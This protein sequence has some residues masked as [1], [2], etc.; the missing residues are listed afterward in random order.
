MTVRHSNYA[1]VIRPSFLLSFVPAERLRAEFNESAREDDSVWLDRSTNEI[2]KPARLE[3]WLDEFSHASLPAIAEDEQDDH[4]RS[5]SLG[6]MISTPWYHA[7][8]KAVLDRRL[9]NPFDTCNHPMAALLV[10]STNDPEPL[11]EFA[12]LYEASNK[13]GSAWPA[14]PW[15]DTNPVL[16]YY[17]LL[18]ETSDEP[19]GGRG[20]A[21]E[22]LGA[23][24]RAYGLHCALVC[25]NSEKSEYLRHQRHLNTDPH[26]KYDESGPA[27]Q[28][29][30][31]PWAEYQ[32]EFE[33]EVEPGSR[34]GEWMAPEDILG[35]KVFL[36]EFVI[37]SLVPHMERCVQ[38]WN[39]T[40]RYPRIS[41][42][43]HCNCS[44][45]R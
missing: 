31:D 43:F 12:T 10:V 9:P 33:C 5:A 36:R 3:D 16:R 14:V 34:Y 15:L 27:H 39:E 30:P 19:D 24:S 45:G 23:V 32:S 42:L 38:N 8:L 35:L 37:Q 40:V 28:S 11:N 29:T 4:P 6:P 21:T 41:H 25:V 22:L 26:F 44:L 2:L 1:S 17:V 20:A 18:H 7:F 13:G